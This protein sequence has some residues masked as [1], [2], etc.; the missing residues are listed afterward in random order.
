MRRSHPQVE[1]KIGALA[2]AAAVLASC[3][4]GQMTESEA[5][6]VLDVVLPLREALGDAYL[7]GGS[8][9]LI[10]VDAQGLRTEFMWDYGM[11]T[12]A[13]ERGVLHMRRPGSRFEPLDANSQSA[14][15]AG[16][17]AEHW[18]RTT[19]EP[20]RHNS[21]DPNRAPEIRSDNHEEIRIWLALHLVGRLKAVGGSKSGR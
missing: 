17:L 18:L 1:A 4:D 15:A 6:L 12:P 16:L 19:Y 8:K 3:G 13:E 7:D 5:A 2:L 9:G 21:L 10:L 20:E 11:D 14:R